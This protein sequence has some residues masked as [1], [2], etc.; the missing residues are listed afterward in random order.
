MSA[1][2]A[3]L[4]RPSPARIAK[5]NGRAE[6]QKQLH[7]TLR[8][9]VYKHARAIPKPGPRRSPARDAKTQG[10]EL[11]SSIN[12]ITRDGRTNWLKEKPV[13]RRVVEQVH[14]ENED[15]IEVE[16]EW[17][18][19]EDQGDGVDRFAGD[20]AGRQ[21]YF[22]SLCSTMT[23]EEAKIFEGGSCKS[24][25]Q[26]QFAHF[27]HRTGLEVFKEHIQIHTPTSKFTHFPQVIKRAGHLDYTEKLDGTAILQGSPERKVYLNLKFRTGSKSSNLK[28]ARSCDTFVKAQL[29]A[30]KNHDCLFINIFEGSGMVGHIGGF[31][32]L[33]TKSQGRVYVGDTLGAAEWLA[34]RR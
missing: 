26:A 31:K 6:C 33:V 13:V 18:N 14:D 21:A 30:L 32:K 10:R 29:K 28:E 3:P 4:R 8:G 17:V 20:E 23:R 7:R 22:E 1:S 24:Y 25:E 5:T 16:T 15:C 12:A 11:V 9:G 27:E 34:A 19:D 2:R